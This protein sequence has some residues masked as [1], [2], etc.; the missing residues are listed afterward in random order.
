MLGDRE[1][2]LELGEALV[3]AG[4][5][6]G[7]GGVDEGDVEGGSAHFGGAEVVDDDERALLEGFG[8][9]GGGGEVAG[10]RGGDDLIQDCALRGGDGA[11]IGGE[12][13][14]EGAGEASG[15]VVW[16]RGGRLRLRLGR[17]R[18]GDRRGG[19]GA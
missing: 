8:A 1:A 4:E 10:G 6:G 19:A 12:R 14:R 9:L 5:L 3:V 11:E 17:V 15:G 2:A 18:G 7:G 16:V 13:E